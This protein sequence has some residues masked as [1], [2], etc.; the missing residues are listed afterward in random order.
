MAKTIFEVRLHRS[1]A[2]HV[3]RLAVS[4][5]VEVED[6]LAIAA[7]RYAQL[8]ESGVDA[9]GRYRGVIKQWPPEAD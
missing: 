4:C 5:G 9:P 2:D 3:I 7:I 1:D 8:V 6:F